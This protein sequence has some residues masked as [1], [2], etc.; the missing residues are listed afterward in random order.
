[1]V[2][3]FINPELHFRQLFI[4]KLQ[5]I[6]PSKYSIFQCSIWKNS[7]LKKTPGCFFPKKKTPPVFFY[8][9][10]SIGITLPFNKKTLPLAIGIVIPNLIVQILIGA[11]NLLDETQVFFKILL[12]HTGWAITGLLW[13]IT[14]LLCSCAPVTLCAHRLL[15]ELL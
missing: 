9:T 4:P 8:S 7:P 1:M 15:C 11:Q 2:Y 13:A 3:T 14:G 5:S 12:E 6:I 10:A